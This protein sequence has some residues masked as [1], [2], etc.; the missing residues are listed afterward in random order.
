MLT[1]AE[2]TAKTIGECEKLDRNTQTIQMIELMK[3]K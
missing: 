3:T 2:L 1:V